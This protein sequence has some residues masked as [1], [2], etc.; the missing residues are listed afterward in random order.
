MFNFFDDVSEFDEV[1]DGSNLI[2]GLKKNG[3]S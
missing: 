2:E 1:F 3:G